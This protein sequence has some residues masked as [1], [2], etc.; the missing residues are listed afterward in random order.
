MTY[1]LNMKQI[2]P[3]AKDMGFTDDLSLYD[4]LKSPIF[5]S[6][7]HPLLTDDGTLT[8]GG[9]KMIGD[10]AKADDDF[11]RLVGLRRNNHG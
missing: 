7:A 5:K 9:L 8:F 2:L 10:I 3:N 4:Y 1:I 6:H 11:L